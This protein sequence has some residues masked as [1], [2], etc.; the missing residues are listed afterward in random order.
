MVLIVCVDDGY[1]MSFN[2]RRQSSDRAV[3]E[4]I[5][6]LSAG[7]RLW[8]GLYS[9]PLFPRDTQV[10]ADE[11]FLSLAEEGDICFAECVD[12]NNW[13]SKAESVIVFHWNR[14]YPSDIKFPY[15]RVTLEWKL[16]RT[17]QLI[18]NSHDKITMEVFTR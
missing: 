2:E 5:V 16:D 8:L 18:G 11:N 9:V 17:Y 13:I 3:I 4:E 7:K 12:V 10:F 6:K 14:K 1:G 15:D